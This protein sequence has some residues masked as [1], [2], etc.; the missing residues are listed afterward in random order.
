MFFEAKDC[1]GCTFPC[2]HLSLRVEKL[3]LFASIEV[4]TLGS[5]CPGVA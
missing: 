5:E 4:K 2:H 3:F 1:V